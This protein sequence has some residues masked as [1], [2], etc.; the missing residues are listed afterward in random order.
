MLRSGRSCGVA[1]HPALLRRSYASLP[2]DFPSQGSG[3]SPLQPSAFSGARA[4]CA[5]PLLGR[6][7][8]AGR[9]WRLSRLGS[10][11]HATQSGRGQPPIC[12]RRTGRHSTT[13][14]THYDPRQFMA[15]TRA[16]DWRFSLPMNRMARPVG[17]S[18]CSAIPKA[19]KQRRLAR[20]M[21]PAHVENVTS[22]LSVKGPGFLPPIHIK[23]GRSGAQ[24]FLPSIRQV[25]LGQR[26]PA[27]EMILHLS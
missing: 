17:L 8:L 26:V 19:A 27:S 12:V 7:S 13:W 11:A 23:P 2:H 5:A 10:Q 3:L 1:A 15:P 20:F 18:C 9:R 21:V 6:A 24:G 14:R 25:A 16:K 4:R 22:F